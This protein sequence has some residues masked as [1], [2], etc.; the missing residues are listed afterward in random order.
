M[1]DPFDRPTVEASARRFDSRLRH[2]IAEN[3]RPRSLV[4]FPCPYIGHGVHVQ[5]GGPSPT[6]A[7]SPLAY[8]LTLGPKPVSSGAL[9]RKAARIAARRRRPH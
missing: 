7:P 9:R 3:I 6:P 1:Y 8:T 4:T 2:K 5:R